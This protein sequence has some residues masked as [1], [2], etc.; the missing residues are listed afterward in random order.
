GPLQLD[1]GG[2]RVRPDGREL[3]PT[4]ALREQIGQV[5]V[6]FGICTEPGN[7]SAGGGSCPFRHRCF[8]CEYFRTDPSYQPGPPGWWRAAAN[9]VSAC[10]QAGTSG[11]RAASDAP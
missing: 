9:L 4:E 6:P 2:R 3:L 1:A 8:G 11:S 10:H 5:A 7:V